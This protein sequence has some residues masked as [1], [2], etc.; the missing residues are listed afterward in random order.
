M[1]ATVAIGRFK[2]P[3]RD[4]KLPAIA[5]AQLAWAQ[6]T[7][8]PATTPEPAFQAGAPSPCHPSDSLMTYQHHLM[9]KHCGENPAPALRILR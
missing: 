1:E 3:N 2:N 6:A 9:C 7:P 4:P 5:R 8:P